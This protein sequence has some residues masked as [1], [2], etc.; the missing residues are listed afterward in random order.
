MF[1]LRA[2][3]LMLV[4]FAAAPL[5]GQD[6]HF[7]QDPVEHLTSEILVFLI[8]VGVAV[9]LYSLIRYRGRTERP[10]S[11][12]LLLLG[13]GILPIVTGMVGTV[14]VFERAEHVEF[15]ASCHLTMQPYVDDLKNPQS[16]SLA[17][18]HYKNRYIASNQCYQ[19][20]TSYGM[21]GTVE[22]KMA[23]MIDTF[24][25][26][27]R[28]YKLPI[29]MREPYKNDDCLKCH[30]DSQKWLGLHGDVKE[31]IFSGDMKC[32]D[33]HGQDHPAHTFERQQAR[34]EK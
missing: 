23:G 25:Y 30:A 15:C 9:V 8:V 6:A 14:L 21:H 29:R 20:H 34:Y 3:L 5:Y 10:E 22:A 27:T 12:G 26:Y 17:A 4:F 1:S 32:L 33:C 31:Q 7:Q 19:C 16:S 24:K 13:V 18:L 11:W 28:T 2:R